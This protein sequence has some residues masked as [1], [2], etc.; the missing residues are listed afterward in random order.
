[1]SKIHE[2]LSELHRMPGV[3]G[4]ALVTRDGL[5]AAQS[6][7]ERF[8]A[9]VVAGLASYLLATTNRCLEEGRMPA[10]SQVVVHASNGKAILAGLEDSCLVVLLDQF[11]DVT[12]AR[13]DVHDAAQR[14]RRLSRLA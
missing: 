6:L 3:K 5:L 10:A 13:R 7:D 2:T 4:A 12:Q 8:G 1:M 11:S 9:D 14:I